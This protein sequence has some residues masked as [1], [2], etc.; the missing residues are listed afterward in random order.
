MAHLEVHLIVRDADA[1]A[2]WYAAALGARETGRLRLPDGRTFAVDLLVGET[3]MAVAGEMAGTP[4]RVPGDTGV[5]AAA[6]HLAV[7]DL[8]AAWQRALDAGAEVFEPVKDAFWG[9]RTGQVLDPSGHR[10]ALNQ[11]V[12]DVSHEE[13][14]RRLGELLE[15]MD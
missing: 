15:S 13:V 9:V 1:A 4:M 12:R 8:D 7:D 10:W 5:S 3:K 2:E 14:E 6:Y 11:R